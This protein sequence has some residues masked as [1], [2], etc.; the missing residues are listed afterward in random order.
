MRSSARRH[1]LLAVL[2]ALLVAMVLA[3]A[4]GCS[5]GGP[6]SGAS[7]TSAQPVDLHVL[8]AS[9]LKAIV[10]SISPEFEKAN[11]V[12]IVASYASSGALQKQIEAGA[13]A[14][15]F[16]S[17]S[18][19]QVA[20]L[21]VDA[22]VSNE[23]TVT[24]AGNELVILVPAGN[25]AGI[26]GPEDLKKADKLATGDPVVAPHGAKAQEWLTGLGLWETLKPKFVFAQN[27]AQTDDYVVRKEVDAAIG[28]GSDAFGKSA[29]QVAY[30]VPAAQYKPIK[31]VA[32]P[33]KASKNQ[34]LAKKFTQ[35][36][37]T[38]QVQGVFTGAG[39]KPAP[40][41]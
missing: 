40:S 26:H 31:Y 3:V 28:F 11:N 7:S 12:K 32:V 24:F 19:K 8:A 37:L 1:P 35:Y 20:S 23:E 17:A 21:T 15:V 33:I 41:K 29:L 16:L 38:E 5:A 18:P 2:A 9:S 22:L 14:D 10:T 36:L 13:P 25:A 4:G 6:A 30:T 39:F 27:A 34:E